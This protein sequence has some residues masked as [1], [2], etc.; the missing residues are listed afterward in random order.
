MKTRNRQL[1]AIIAI[2]AF[3]LAAMIGLIFMF[4]V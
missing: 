2:V 3:S 1:G 4:W